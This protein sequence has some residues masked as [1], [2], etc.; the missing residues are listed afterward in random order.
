MGKVF[1]AFSP[2]SPDYDKSLP[3]T[4]FTPGEFD[5][6]DNPDSV[7]G[8]GGSS[9]SFKQKRQTI[10]DIPR[11]NLSSVMDEQ[12]SQSSNESEKIENGEN[13]ENNFVIKT[14]SS[15][16]KEKNEERNGKH[17]SLDVSRRLQSFFL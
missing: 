4:G 13:K 8:E 5:M 3:R 14:P 16:G 9:N 1:G 2:F 15:H 11:L 7:W 6:V 17:S 10:T 12:P